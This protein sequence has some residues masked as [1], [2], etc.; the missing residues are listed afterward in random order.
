MVVSTTVT[1]NASINNFTGASFQVINVS[2]VVRE[3]DMLPLVRVNV[4][5]CVPKIFTFAGRDWYA[6]F[7]LEKGIGKRLM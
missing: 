5:E 7:N 4:R 2:G 6:L 3:Q 1:V